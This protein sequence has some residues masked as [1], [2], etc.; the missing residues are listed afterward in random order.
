M[1]QNLASAV[2]DFHRARLR[3]QL[4]SVVARLTGRSAELLSYEE[5]RRQLRARERYS[6]H[7][8]DIP[9]DAIVGSVGRYKDFTR[10]FLPKQAGAQERWARVEIAMTGMEGVPPIDVY[11]VG[12][13]Y[14]VRD[15]NHRVSVAKELGADHIQAYVTDVEIRVPLT[16]DAEPDDLIIKAEHTEFLE[17]T[18]LD[19][20]RPEANLRVTVP[21]RYQILEEHI[22]V[23]RYFMGQHEERHIPYG[24]AA[25]HW[26]DEVYQPV[27]RLIRERGILR[28]FPERTETDL[29]L[30]LSQHRAELEQQ[31]SWQITPE[32]AASDL[33]SRFSQQPGRVIQRIGRRVLKAITPDELE[34]GPPT[35]RWREERLAPRQDDRLFANILVAIRGDESGWVALEQALEVAH[36]EHARLHGLHVVPHE[37]QTEHPDA[38]AIQETFERRC[39]AAGVEGRLAYEVGPVQRKICERA[40]WNDLVVTSLN[41]PPLP[42][43]MSKI[44]SGIVTLIRRCPRPVLVVP[45]EPSSLEH[46]LLAYDGTPKAREALFVATYLAGRWRV[47]LTVVA[48]TEGDRDAGTAVEDAHTYLENHRVQATWVAEQRWGDESVADAILRR[49]AADNCDLIL[50]GGYGMGPVV[51]AVIGSTVDRILR[52]STRPILICR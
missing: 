7:L 6:H 34:P 47:P 48:V 2:E 20:T 3:A 43:P 29:Y 31:L 40:R 27:A 49:A 28:D 50:M 41:Y 11:R 42:G 14:F 37:Q 5:V 15:G 24:Q 35:G 13:A 32:M 8:E 9:L 12:D 16:P 18:R 51:E 26:Y 19:R 52:K 25:A 21:G 4:E 44:N 46:A 33:A 1:P 23:H 36:R 45:D 38:R 30:W 39:S 17:H 22:A 10:S